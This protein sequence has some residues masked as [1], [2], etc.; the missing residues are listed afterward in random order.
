LITS[1]VYSAVC[2]C[3]KNCHNCL[4]YPNTATVALQNVR[5][6][7]SMVS[8]CLRNISY[9]EEIR[10]MI[11]GSLSATNGVL[12]STAMQQTHSN[13]RNTKERFTTTKHRYNIQQ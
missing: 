3:D 8:F 4:H 10:I 7:L 2:N 9:V 6:G 5:T 11:L 1:S 12:T 13:I